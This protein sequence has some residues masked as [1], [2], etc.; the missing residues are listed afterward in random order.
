LAAGLALACSDGAGPPSELADTESSGIQSTTQRSTIPAAEFGPLGWRPSEQPREFTGFAMTSDGEIL[1][2]PDGGWLFDHDAGIML[3][4][5]MPIEAFHV[6]F[7]AVKGQT[8][9]V[10]IN[11]LDTAC[12]PGT[13]YYY[14]NGHRETQVCPYLHFEVRDGSLLAGPDGTPIAYGDSVLITV[15]V[16]STAILARMEPSG[17][18]F[19]PSD[20]PVLE[21]WYTGADHDFNGDGVEDSVDNYIK[22]NLLGMFTQQGA[23]DSWMILS[24]RHSTYMEK[25][26]AFLDHFSGFAVAY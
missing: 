17:L 26:K 3:S 23:D 5:T 14:D 8:R 25:F 18:Q 13:T 24:S 15:T 6:S 20:P 19:D 2:A 22:S 12:V 21:M 10:Q 1:E 16:D 9:S 11:Y 4:V 7:W